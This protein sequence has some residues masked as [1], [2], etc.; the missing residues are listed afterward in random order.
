MVSQ[1][2]GVLAESES[3]RRGHG[4]RS[5]KVTGRDGETQTK[6]TRCFVLANF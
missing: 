4:V 3:I 5:V 6:T 1:I 2:C